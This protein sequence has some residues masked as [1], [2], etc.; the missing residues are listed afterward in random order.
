M[1]DPV[2][3][4]Q[5]GVTSAVT[6]SVPL[7]AHA[8]T[9]RKSRTARLLEQLRGMSE[10]I[11]SLPDEHPA[12][13]TLLKA[14]DPVASRLA[15]I[16]AEQLTIRREPAAIALG[17]ALAIAGANLGVFALTQRISL[18]WVA[19]AVPLFVFG[20]FGA[21]YEVTGGKSRRQRGRTEQE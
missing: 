6:L 5:V 9:G 14:S 2:N 17:V 19:L 21:T 13:E 1:A 15:Q 4:L 3:W 20:M 16:S 18:W 12:R 11:K 10:V 7:V 8:I